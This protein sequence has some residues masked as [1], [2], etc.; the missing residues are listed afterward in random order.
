VS[1]AESPGFRT[2]EHTGETIQPSRYTLYFVLFFFLSGGFVLW[3][4]SV[5]GVELVIWVDSRT[6]FRDM[7]F[8]M[9]HGYGLGSNFR[10]EAWAATK[11]ATSRF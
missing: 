9:I 3:L 1:S 5:C 4:E 6:G 2:K 7:L 11:L 8:W 10:G